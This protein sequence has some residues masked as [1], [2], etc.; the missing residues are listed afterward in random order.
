ME[1]LYLTLGISQDADDE[2]V[3]MAYE[4]LYLF[5]HSAEYQSV[6]SDIDIKLANIAVS[7]NIL[8]CATK[9]KSYDEMWLHHQAEKSLDALVDVPDM[10]YEFEVDS[11]IKEQW[12]ETVEQYPQLVV[13]YDNLACLSNVLAF[14]FKAYI[15]ESQ[16][17]EESERLA[18]IM[19][20]QYIQRF[21]GEDQNIKPLAKGLLTT[22]SPSDLVTVDELFD[23]QGIEVNAQIPIDNN[24]DGVNSSLSSNNN[25]V[26]QLK[27]N[28]IHANNSNDVQ[29]VSDSCDRKEVIHRLVSKE[30]RDHRHLAKKATAKG[31][32]I[33]L[34]LFIVSNLA[35]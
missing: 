7:Y 5:Y 3:M 32:L 29:N 13:L 28:N 20:A 19:C 25:T 24:Q 16:R 26:T 18:Y 31:S 11:E 12:N 27:D 34:G 14:S 17:F 9:R 4:D 22:H 8:K 30:D 35:A 15:L 6:Y 1:N 10:S 33:L 2:A 23:T 21:F